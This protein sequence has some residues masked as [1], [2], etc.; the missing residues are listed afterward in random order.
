MKVYISSSWKNR[1]EVRAFAKLLRD[2]AHEVYDFTDPNCRKTPEIPPE[3]FPEQFDPDKHHY[4]VYLDRKEWRMA[5]EENRLAIEESEVIALLLP[6]GIDSTADWALG[7]GMGKKSCV[8]GHPKKG[9]RSPVHLWANAM[10]DTT[11]QALNWI[12]RLEP[13]NDQ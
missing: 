10:M 7:V 4:P 9:E 2:C 3:R 12:N 13:T 11:Q 6:C 8:I 1:E 5:V